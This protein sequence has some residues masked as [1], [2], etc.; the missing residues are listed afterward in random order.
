MNLRLLAFLSIFLFILSACESEEARKA[1]R[2]V[3]IQAEAAKRLDE[4]LLSR[5]G[6]C[7]ERLL[8]KVTEKTDSILM[9]EAQE[10][11]KQDTLAIPNRPTKPERP[12]LK[13]AKDTSAVK[14]I[15]E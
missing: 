12:R 15:V 11:I 2:N 14:P 13:T 5:V 8:E 9:R 10:L 3:L 7:E 6:I 4:Y 1:R